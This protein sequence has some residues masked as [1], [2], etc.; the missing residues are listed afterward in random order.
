MVYLCLSL[1]E[2]SRRGKY[3]SVY[4]VTHKQDITVPGVR[5]EI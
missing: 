5:K 3:T 2:V 1:L 4:S